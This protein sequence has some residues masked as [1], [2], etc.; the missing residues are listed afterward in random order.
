LSPF[1][2]VLVLV[3]EIVGPENDPAAHD[4]SVT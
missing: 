1:W 2:S 4:K 3:P